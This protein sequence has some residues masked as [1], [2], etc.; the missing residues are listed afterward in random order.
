MIEACARADARGAR[1]VSGARRS[2][3]L[4]E[5][6]TAKMKRYVGELRS[7]WSGGVKGL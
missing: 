4:R 7:V 6:L 2:N 1:V 5:S 3:G